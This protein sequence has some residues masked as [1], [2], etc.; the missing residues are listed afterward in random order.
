[1]N[2]ISNNNTDKIFENIKHIDENGNEYWYARELQKVLEYKDW[3]NFQKVIDKAVIAAKN[4]VSTKEDWVVGHVKEVAPYLEEKLD[5]LAA[6]YD[7]ITERRGMGFMQGLELTI[8]PGDVVNKGI[9]KGILMLTAGTNV[10]RLLP[11]LVISKEEID[12]MYEILD[13]VFAEMK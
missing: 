5:E 7:C 3:R 8:K 11:P 6:K 10:L 9:E 1:M 13:S 12:K 2:K 4:S